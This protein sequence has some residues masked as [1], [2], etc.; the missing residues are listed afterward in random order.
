MTPVTG[1]VVSTMTP[2]E[3]AAMHSVAALQASIRAKYFTP[4]VNLRSSN[5]TSVREYEYL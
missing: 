5:F 1:G 4:G 3:H 2:S